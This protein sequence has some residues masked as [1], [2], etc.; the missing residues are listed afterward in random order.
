MGLDPGS[1]GSHPGLQ[2]ALSRCATGAALFPTFFNLTSWCFFLFVC[3]FWYIKTHVYVVRFIIV[4][5]VAG[6]PHSKI[7]ELFTH[8]LKK[9]IKDLFMSKRER[10][11]HR[12]I[13]AGSMQGA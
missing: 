12:Q 5:K 6:F 1:L 10:Q 4:I 9:C 3:S 7:I 13:E 8:F 2:A 11:R